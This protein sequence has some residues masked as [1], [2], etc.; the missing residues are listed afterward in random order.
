MTGWLQ[1]V[2][3]GPRQSPRE[4]LLAAMT[5]FANPELAARAVQ[6]YDNPQEFEAYLDGLYLEPPWAEHQRA[7]EPAELAFEIFSELLTQNG[8]LGNID[9]KTGH[10]GIFEVFDR[11]FA[12]SGLPIVTDAEKIEAERIIAASKER[13]VFMALWKYLDALA[14][15][16]ERDV[17]H[18]Y[19]GSDAHAPALLTPEARKRWRSAKFGKG[20]RVIP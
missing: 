15:A 11:L 5:D 3:G 13:T 18:F 14:R 10:E 6:F 17:V 19:T 8:Y 9:W 12:S 2:L 1:N 20:F 7:P 16:R 4:I